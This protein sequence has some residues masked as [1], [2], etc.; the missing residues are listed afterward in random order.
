M[1]LVCPLCGRFVS[2]T[3]FDPSGFSDDI[4]C[5]EVVGL[6]RGRGVKV[7]E[8]YS[9]LNPGD[10]TIELI[11]NRIFDLS[12]LLLN[13]GCLNREE[14]LSS[15]EINVADPAEISSL[16][17]KNATLS[18]E[19]DNTKKSRDEWIANRETWKSHAETLNTRLQEITKTRD[20]LRTD[21]DKWKN[22]AE[23][24]ETSLEEAEASRKHWHDE[25]LEEESEL[26]DVYSQINELTGRIEDVV[27]VSLNQN[28]SLAALKS[29]VDYLIN[30]YEA[31]EAE[32]E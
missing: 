7:T 31:L 13:S 9:I 26:E 30:E 3:Y 12:K 4:Y 21:R 10:A 27:N 16:E 24:L 6:G 28:D 19:L 25:Y 32:E 8:K 29:S 18:T 17:E 20:E 22:E 14:L 23:A 2:L 11:K 15:L 1:Q 5:V